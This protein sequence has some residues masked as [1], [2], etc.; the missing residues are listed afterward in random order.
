MRVDALTNLGRPPV[1]EAEFLHDF[2]L[3]ESRHDVN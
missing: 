2:I 1:E 3:H